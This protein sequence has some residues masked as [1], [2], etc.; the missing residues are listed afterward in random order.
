LRSYIDENLRV[1]VDVSELQDGGTSVPLRWMYPD[2]WCEQLF[3]GLEGAA[4]LRIEP[5][6]SALVKLTPKT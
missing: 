2:N 6:E 3:P 4:V 1:F 5:V